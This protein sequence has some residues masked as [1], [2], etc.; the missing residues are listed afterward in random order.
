MNAF[1]QSSHGGAGSPCLMTVS[2][3][4][5]VATTYSLLSVHH[6]SVFQRL[7][8]DLFL[9]FVSHQIITYTSLNHVRSLFT[10]MAAEKSPAPATGTGSLPKIIPLRK[11]VSEKK[12]AMRQLT[13]QHKLEKLAAFSPCCE[14]KVPPEMCDC[15]G[16]QCPAPGTSDGSQVTICS[17]C[18]HY[19]SAHISRMQTMSCE[20]IDKLLDM[21]ADLEAISSMHTYSSD[22]NT[23]EHAAFLSRQLEQHIRGMNPD[24]A[25]FLPMDPP[26]FEEPNIATGLNNFCVITC[27][28]TKTD[29]RSI[30][31]YSE[32]FVKFMNNYCLQEP[33]AWAAS[34][35]G[36]DV[37]EYKI[38]FTRW[39]Y[40]FYVPSFC[41]SLTAHDLTEMFGRQ[42]LKQVFHFF[43]GV[44]LQQLTTENNFI[45]E[46]KALQ[47]KKYLP[48]FLKIL[49]GDIFSDKSISW[50]FKEMLR[51]PYSPVTSSPQLIPGQTCSGGG[52]P[53]VVDLSPE[54]PQETETHGSCT[55]PSPVQSGSQIVIPSSSM[56]MDAP[57]TPSRE[58]NDL[59]TA[60]H[61]TTT[62]QSLDQSVP[63][64][65]QS[66]HQPSES[67]T[68]VNTTSSPAANPP[69][70]DLDDDIRPASPTIVS[71]PEILKRENSSHPPFH[72]M[73]CNGRFVC[74][75]LFQR[76]VKQHQSTTKS[77]GRMN[78]RFECQVCDRTFLYHQSRAH[79]IITK[80]PEHFNI[81]HSA[82][83]DGQKRVPPLV[84]MD[85]QKS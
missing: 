45:P 16:Y 52:S 74:E 77:K 38:T 63:C 42:F 51:A 62:G 32:M 31:A 69:V 56:S 43:E 24:E 15:S 59:K 29:R 50:T 8:H 6:V 66:S 81:S 36:S 58:A 18:G 39:F 84:L 21:I 33:E 40:F 17:R 27:Q 60:L 35:P 49:E 57:A 48:P 5:S 85:V 19:L 23:K 20:K 46:E 10:L 65:S 79:H 3:V 4:V 30:S 9:S 47:L 11:A 64:S 76:H 78:C 73:Y 67:R 28:E 44:M 68:E 83:T 13:H 41:S 2:C 26:P 25:I 54:P 22:T 7:K 34:N 71:L 72:C 70:S 80:H 61:L 53:E 75:K 14:R 1:R 55:D 37:Q 82:L 12:A